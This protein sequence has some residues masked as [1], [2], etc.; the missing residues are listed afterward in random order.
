MGIVY[1]GD[2]EKVLGKDR[3]DGCIVLWRYLVSLN[4]IFI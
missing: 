2:D 1:G 3:G 4:G